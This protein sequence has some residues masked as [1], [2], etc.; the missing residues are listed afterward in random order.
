MLIASL[1]L[2]CSYPNI[3]L[4]GAQTDLLELL[5]QDCS[6]YKIHPEHAS[7][8]VRSLC[9]PS[10]M[11]HHMYMLFVAGICKFFLALI[12]FG[13]MVPAGMFIPPLVIGA[14]FGRVLGF[15][16]MRLHGAIGNTF[17]FSVCLP[18]TQC[19]HPSI[20]ALIGAAGVLGGFTRMTVSL[21]VILFEACSLRFLLLFV[22]LCV[23]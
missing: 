22:C 14:C 7:T 23:C 11:D 1:T 5:F 13:S 2:L 8:L 19:V 12:T 9:E 15:L 6:D 3:Y 20:Y 17:V 21:T 16:M 10:G 4:R 18:N